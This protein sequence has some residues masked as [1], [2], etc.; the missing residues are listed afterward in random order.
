MKKNIRKVCE[1][2]GTAC[3]DG[4]RYIVAQKV[5]SMCAWK[6]V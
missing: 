4:A 3:T 2:T 6:K 1:N 5:S